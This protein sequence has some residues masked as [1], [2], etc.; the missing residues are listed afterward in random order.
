MKKHRVGRLV[1]ALAA[2]LLSDVLC[3]VI[4]YTYCALQWGSRYA[5]YSAPAGTAFLYAIPFGIGIP[6]CFWRCSSTGRSGRRRLKTHK[7]SQGRPVLRNCG[8]MGRGSEGAAGRM[9]CVPRATETAA[10][11]NI[12]SK[13]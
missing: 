5:G 11:R 6:A 7:A 12:P 2:I 8:E 1:F 4:A 13:A 10:S 9:R 3:A